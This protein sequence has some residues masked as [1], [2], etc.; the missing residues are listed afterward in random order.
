MSITIRYEIKLKNSEITDDIIEQ[1][2]DQVCRSEIIDI[3]RL[4]P[5]TV[6][7]VN[8]NIIEITGIIEDPLLRFIKEQNINYKNLCS[9]CSFMYIREGF[10]TCEN[11]VYK[12][13]IPINLISFIFNERHKVMN[14]QY[15]KLITNTVCIYDEDDEDYEIDYDLIFISCDMK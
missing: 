15:K 2:H 9:F 14:F 4:I 12:C 13:D 10:N 6:S 7:I 5:Q 1:I 11:C 3:P 8:K